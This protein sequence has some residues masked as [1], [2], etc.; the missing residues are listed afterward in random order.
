MQVD[1]QRDIGVNAAGL[2]S[3]CL[4]FQDYSD[5]NSSPA[6]CNVTGKMYLTKTYRKIAIIYGLNLKPQNCTSASQ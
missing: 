4:C 6:Q 3:V 2:T 5:N 1:G